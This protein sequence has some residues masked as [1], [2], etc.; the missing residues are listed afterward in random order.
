MANKLIFSIMK[1]K[2]LI[3]LSFLFISCTSSKINNIFVPKFTGINPVSYTD[4]TYLNSN[5]TVIVSAMNGRIAYRYN[6][7]LD[8]KLITKIND[9]VYVVAYNK[10]LNHI[11]ISTLN[12]GVIVVNLEN[13]KIIYK[14][15]LNN[16]WTL[17]L[18]YSSEGNYLFANDQEGNR[19]I[20]QTKNKYEKL[21]IN[22]TFPKG[23]IYSIQNDI[24]LFVTKDKL[25]FWSWS[26]NKIINEVQ[27]KFDKLK[28]IDSDSNILSLNHNK[29]NLNKPN[30]NKPSINI[31]H[32]GWYRSLDGLS[33]A[34]IKQVKE[35][36]LPILENHFSDPNYE[37]FLTDAK[38]TNDKIITSSIDRSVRIWDKKSGE[39]IKVILG[40]K[41]TVNKIKVSPQ[42][43]QVVTIDL[44]GGI[45]FTDI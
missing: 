9:E 43:N 22:E 27:T 42:A 36:G 1:N 31:S 21:T 24:L 38:M 33:N 11:A 13:N 37:M 3:F 44:K 12:S 30:E 7:N 39:L 45:K 4:V 18:K 29:C 40:H 23:H 26:Q 41:G 35:A 6:D 32:S 28:D 2:L 19:F 25:N 14:L 34:E 17:N 5:D 15:P 20:W 8:E 10:Q 16:T